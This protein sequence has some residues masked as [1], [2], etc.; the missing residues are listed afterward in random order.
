MPRFLT[1]SN[2]LL[3]L[4]ARIRS[5]T[6]RSTLYDCLGRTRAAIEAQKRGSTP[7]RCC[8][9][10]TGFLGVSRSKEAQEF[11]VDLPKAVGSTVAVLVGRSTERTLLHGSGG[12]PTHIFRDRPAVAPVRARDVPYGVH[13]GEDSDS[14][15][16]CIDFLFF[17]FFFF[18][19]AVT[20]RAEAA[21]R[22]HQLRMDA[23]DRAV[24]MQ[25]L[26]FPRV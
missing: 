25:D 9:S 17:L 13:G 23:R 15:R 12:T 24:S 14:L 18:L 10:A 7:K 11:E 26:P 16:H 1:T 4:D 22:L 21:A 8:I 2:V 6:R 20:P 3:R 5:D 19:K